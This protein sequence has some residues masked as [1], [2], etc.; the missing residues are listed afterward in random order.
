MAGSIFI[1]LDA[2]KYMPTKIMVASSAN[3]AQILVT[4]ML[5]GASGTKSMLNS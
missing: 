5:H 2:G 4:T 1:A 3:V